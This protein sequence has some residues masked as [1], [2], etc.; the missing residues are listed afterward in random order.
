MSDVCENIRDT[1]DS[2]NG[3]EDIGHEI[4]ISYDADEQYSWYYISNFK[5]YNYDGNI[6][7]EFR[8][9]PKMISGGR[10]LALDKME[11]LQEEFPNANIKYIDCTLPDAISGNPKDAFGERRGLQNMEQKYNY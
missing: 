11:S 9:Y 3:I 8:K 6:I 5:F 10:R 1:V 2:F 4:T 7:M